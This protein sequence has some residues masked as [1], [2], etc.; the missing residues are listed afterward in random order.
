MSSSSE[1]AINFNQLPTLFLSLIEG[2][3]LNLATISVYNS[4]LSSLRS[5]I[6]FGAIAPYKNLF[7]YSLIVLLTTKNLAASPLSRLAAFD[8]ISHRFHLSFKLHFIQISVLSAFNIHQLIVSAKFCKS[9]FVN[10]RNSISVL[11]SR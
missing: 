9:T 6:Y 4:E 11:N 1:G 7:T 5:K 10:N 2:E 8:T 3:K